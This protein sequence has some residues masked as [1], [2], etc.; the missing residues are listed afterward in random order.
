MKMNKEVFV[1]LSGQ[2]LSSFFF[3]QTQS[4][5]ILLLILLLMSVMLMNM[6]TNNEWDMIWDLEVWGLVV[7]SKEAHTLKLRLSS[8]QPCRIAASKHAFKKLVAHIS[9]VFF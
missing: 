5:L 1:F 9:C 3:Y 8:R 2:F 4:S 7:R 6:V